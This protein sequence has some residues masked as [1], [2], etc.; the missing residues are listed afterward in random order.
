[1]KKLPKTKKK[2][3][4]LQKKIGKIHKY[5]TKIYKMTSILWLRERDREKEGKRKKILLSIEKWDAARCDLWKIKYR[6]QWF[7]NTIISFIFKC[8]NRNYSKFNRNCSRTAKDEW[9]WQNMNDLW[10]FM[11]AS[12]IV[13]A[14][15]LKWN[16]LN[17]CKTR[18]RCK[19]DN[20]E[21]WQKDADNSLTNSFH[22]L[23]LFMSIKRAK[24]IKL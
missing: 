1:M 10:I 23:H 19:F 4:I 11:A 13:F 16:R 12:L 9:N 24:W 6:R 17:S 18:T 14:M 22:P 15:K 21:Q 7:K 2:Q 20:K 3:R 5:F 8:R